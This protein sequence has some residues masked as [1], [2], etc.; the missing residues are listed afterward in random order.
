MNEWPKRKLDDLPRELQSLTRRIVANANQ[1]LRAPPW[2][3]VLLDVV[4]DGTRCRLERVRQHGDE[5]RLLSPRERE[6][7]VSIA[8]GQTNQAIAR[9]L[10]ISEWTVNTY[11]RRAFAKLGVRSRAALVDRFSATDQRR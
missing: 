7:T 11:V 6:I 2:E 8:Q 9:D 10:G 1:S 5:F 3:L 4:V